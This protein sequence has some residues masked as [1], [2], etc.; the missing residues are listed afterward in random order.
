MVVY[1]MCV[2][3]VLTVSKNCPTSLFELWSMYAAR[4]VWNHFYL[5]IR[6]LTFDSCQKNQDDFY[7][8]LSRANLVDLFLLFTVTTSLSIIYYQL[9]VCLI[10]IYQNVIC[11]MS[12]LISLIVMVGFLSLDYQQ[13][14]I[15]SKLSTASYQQQV[16]NSKLLNLL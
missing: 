7:Q 6:L 15:N 8:N 1:N 5:D 14:V 2:L 10:F 13:Q 4:T 11:Q 16:I 3:R 9:F 12:V